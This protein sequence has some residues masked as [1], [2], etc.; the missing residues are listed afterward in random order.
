[1]ETNAQ[2]DSF[3]KFWKNRMINAVEKDQKQFLIKWKNIF[4]L[5][6]AQKN[7]RAKQIYGAK[8]DI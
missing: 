4:S 8:S 5:I 1:M 6:L 7:D 2:S 3:I